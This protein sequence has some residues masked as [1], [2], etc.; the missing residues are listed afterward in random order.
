MRKLAASLLLFFLTAT[1]S[2]AEIKSIS[3]TIFGMD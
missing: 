1:S 2:V 3:I